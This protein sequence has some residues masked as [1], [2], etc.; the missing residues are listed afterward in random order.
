MRGYV[1][2]DLILTQ[3]EALLI[4]IN[5]RLTT[6]YIGLRQVIDFNLAEAIWDARFRD[7]LPSQ[8]RLIGHITFTKD[9]LRRALTLEAT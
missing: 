7:N 4:E 8:V 9:Q 3:D 6:S 5:P 2:V 1:G